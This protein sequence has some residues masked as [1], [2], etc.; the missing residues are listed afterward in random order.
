LHDDTARTLVFAKT[1]QCIAYRMNHMELLHRA[2]I[3]QQIL[4][5]LVPGHAGAALAAENPARA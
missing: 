1:S 5:W 4:S 2:E 3:T